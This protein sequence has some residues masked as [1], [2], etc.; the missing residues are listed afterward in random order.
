MYVPEILNKDKC[1]AI[2]TDKQPPPP[3]SRFLPTPRVPHQMCIRDRVNGAAGDFFTGRV[4]I[5]S[6]ETV[7][8]THL[9]NHK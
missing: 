9:P 2:R 1:W 6:I 3:A 4:V 5:S 8:Y 7:S